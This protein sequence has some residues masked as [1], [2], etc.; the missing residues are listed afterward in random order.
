MRRVG[1]IATSPGSGVVSSRARDQRLIALVAQRIDGP[2]VIG[3]QFAVERLEVVVGGDEAPVAFEFIAAHDL[4]AVFVDEQPLVP[5][6]RRIEL[7]DVCIERHRLADQPRRRRSLSDCHTF[8]E[9]AS[10]SWMP[11]NVKVMPLRF[12]CQ[13]VP[14]CMP[15]S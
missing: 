9:I 12:C 2:D 7:D 10:R 15:F 13:R 6:V 8:S 11:E 5:A 14:S 3:Q 4:A 1:T